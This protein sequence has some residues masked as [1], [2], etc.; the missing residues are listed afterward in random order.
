MRGRITFR[1]A[2]IEAVKRS[3]D[4]SWRQKLRL[5]LVLALRPAAREAV[6]EDALR[7]VNSQ[8]MAIASAEALIDLDK[9]ERLLQILIEYLPEIIALIELIIGL[10]GSA[11]DTAETQA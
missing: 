2:I 6:E 4:L 11:E 8:G 5:R 3:P 7:H 1:E 10:F 9:L